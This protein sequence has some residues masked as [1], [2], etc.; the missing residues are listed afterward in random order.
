MDSTYT[1][2]LTP[3][4]NE[5]MRDA[6]ESLNASHERA[7]ARWETSAAGCEIP[8]PNDIID[9]IRCEEDLQLILAAVADAFREA[10]GMDAP[11]TME[12]V[13]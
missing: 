8:Q 7:M 2:T 4:V 6:L 13:A 9:H 10:N 3:P 5:I 11:K 1:I 12:V